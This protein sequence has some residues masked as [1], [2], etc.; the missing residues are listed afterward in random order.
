MKRFLLTL[1]TAVLVSVGVAYAETDVLL[2]FDLLKTE[3]DKEKSEKQMKA[4][5]KEHDDTTI[6]YSSQAGTTFGDDQKQTMKT[7]L[8]IANWQVELASSAQTI[9]NMSQTM[10]RPAQVSKAS[11]FKTNQKD[12]VAE[13]SVLGIRVFFPT[14]VGTNSWA[15]IKPPF[16]IPVYSTLDKYTKD[17]T[18]N[19]DMFGKQ[20]DGPSATIEK[21]VA[22]KEKPLDQRTARQG[23]F[24]VLKNVGTIKEVQISVLG[25]NYP[26]SISLV[27]ENDKGQEYTIFMGFLQFDG[28][29]ELRWVNPNYQ[30]DV[31]N[32]V[33]FASPLYPKSEPFVKLK[34][35]LIQ[36]DG[37]KDGGDFIS[38][39]KQIDVIYDKAMEDD[40][41]IELDDEK[42]W[43][44][45]ADREQN[46]RK[47]ELTRIGTMQ[48]LRSL[49]EKRM[50]KPS[51]TF[52]PDKKTTTST[53]TTTTTTTPANP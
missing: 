22:E 10:I 49:E 42:L 36:K 43:N 3:L 14:L 28:W 8:A 6:D 44:I 48:V 5:Y 50:A 29:R 21:R 24:G 13:K 34:G 7:S 37:I 11:T 23:G 45:M 38:Y 25:R 2:D 32:R 9:E 12:P 41:I 30:T 47:F 20:F 53:T 35:I 33:L 27:L 26:H 39:I 1:S 17:S 18:K 52:N 4:I 31:R 40:R 16:D 19:A 51:E 15:M 46:R